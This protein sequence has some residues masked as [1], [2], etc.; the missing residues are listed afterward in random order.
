MPGPPPFPQPRMAGAF[1]QRRRATRAR[2][3]RCVSPRP[4]RTTAGS[5]RHRAARKRRHGGGSRGID[6]RLQTRRRQRHQRC[7][8]GDVAPER[9][10]RRMHQASPLHRGQAFDRR[11]PRI[12][13]EAEHRGRAERAVALRFDERRAARRRRLRGQRRR[14]LV[15]DRVRRGRGLELRPRRRCGRSRVPRATAPQARSRTWSADDRRRCAHTRTRPRARRAPIARSAPARTRARAPR[16]TRGTLRSRCH[17]IGSSGLGCGAGGQ[18]SAASPATQRASSGTPAASSR[19]E[20]WIGAATVSGWNTSLPASAASVATASPRAIRDA[21]EPSVANRARSSSQA[22]RACHSADESEPCPGQ[23]AAASQRRHA[24]VHSRGDARAGIRS[25]A[26]AARQRF[27]SEGCVA[28]TAPIASSSEMSRRPSRSQSASRC[29]HHSDS[30][31]EAGDVGRAQKRRRLARPATARAQGRSTRAPRR[32]AERR[33]PRR[34]A[35]GCTDARR[36]PAPATAAPDRECP[37]PSARTSSRRDA[38][39]SIAMPMRRVRIGKRPFTRPLKR[40][41]DLVARGRAGGTPCLRTAVRVRH[42]GMARDSHSG[43][44]QR[45]EEPLLLRRDLDEPRQHDRWRRATRARRPRG[46]RANPAI[47]RDPA[48]CRGRGSPRRYRPSARAPRNRRRLRPTRASWARPFPTHGRATR[49]RRRA[50]PRPARRSATWRRS[51]RWSP[52]GTRL[53]R[54]RGAAAVHRRSPMAMTSSHSRS[55]QPL[56]GMTVGAFQTLRPAARCA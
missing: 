26:R 24:S 16:S 18:R 34:Q 41:D 4:S 49:R 45:S 48:R 31:G 36:L 14:P 1:V 23:P 9:G 3:S 40:K 43:R 10:Q 6:A 8:I 27:A 20:I 55:S 7:V 52:T 51:R 22:P 30:S 15:G 37:R 25:P 21:T 28:A 44:R 13:A 17:A 2:W 5:R 35:T 33:S 38:K 54:A 56:Q 42:R 11:R 32:S 19:P 47:A 12:R 39:S 46:A 29:A 53:P 50:R